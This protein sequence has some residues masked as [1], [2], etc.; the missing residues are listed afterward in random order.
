[1]LKRL[2]I[3]LLALSILMLYSCESISEKEKNEKERFDTIDDIPL[4]TAQAPNYRFEEERYIVHYFSYSYEDAYETYERLK[5][6]GIAFGTKP[7]SFAAFD[8][9]DDE[10][11]A[12]YLF[13]G[14]ATAESYASR[15]EKSF[16]ELDFEN[17]RVD[18]RCCLFYKNRY[19]NQYNNSVLG[20]DKFPYQ[21]FCRFYLSYSFPLEKIKNIDFESL[22]LFFRD[23][24]EGINYYKVEYEG[25]YMVSI[26]SHEPITNEFFD[27][28]KD[29]FV[30][31]N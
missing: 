4:T 16:Y 19:E 30:I 23:K 12:G 15:K 31:F 10:L 8:Y 26:E 28:I 22:T 6:R 14:T 11:F 9:Y 18:L 29:N 2:L 25:I 21:P 24:D 7:A 27:K 3:L 20:I 17:G 13:I 1:M 5:D